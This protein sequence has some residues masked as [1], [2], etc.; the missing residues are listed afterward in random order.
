[1]KVDLIECPSAADWMEVKRRALVTVGLNPVTAPTAKWKKAILTALHS[2]IRYLRFSFYIECPSYV[3]THLARHIHAQPY[4]QTQRSDRTGI[5][6]STLPQNMLVAMIYD[7]NAE[8]L[9]TIAHKRLCRLADPATQE[10]VREMCELAESMCPEF[11]GLLVSNCKYLGRCPE[12]YPCGGDS[13]C[14]TQN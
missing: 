11:E 10:V 9:M 6:R 1:M 2:P 5:D 14:S 3:A 12:M 4:I 7:V 13:A 8:E